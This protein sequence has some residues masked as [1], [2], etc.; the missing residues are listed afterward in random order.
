[1]GDGTTS[2]VLLAAEILKQ[3]KVFVEDGLHPQVRMMMM[4]GSGGGGGGASGSGGYGNDDDDDDN[5]RV[6]FFMG[7]E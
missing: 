1:M 4:V 6:I 3:V 7:S 5:D 2:V